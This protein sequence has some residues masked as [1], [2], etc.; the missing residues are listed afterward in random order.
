MKFTRTLKLVTMIFSLKVICLQKNRVSSYRKIDLCDNKTIRSRICKLDPDQRFV[1]DLFVKYAR[2]LKLAEKGYGPFPPPP[3]LVIEGNAGSGK[4]ELIHNLCMVL[5][6]EFRQAGDN[7]ENPYILKGSFTGEAACNIKGQTLTSLFNLGFGN[8]LS[9]MSDSLRDKKRD[10]LGNLK[11]LIID[12]YSM[13]RSDMTYQIDSRLKEIRIN[14]ECFGGVSV[15]LLGNL[16]QLQPVKG[17]YIFEEPVDDSW[18]LGHQFQSLWEL[19]TPIKL[20]Y[21]HRQD[22][23]LQFSNM[24]NR[25]SLGIVNREDLEL[26][27]TRV[28]RDDD[29]CIPQDTLYIFPLKRTVKK[30]NEKV[31]ESLEGELVVLKATNILKTRKH[32]E[33]YVDKDDDKVRNTPLLSTL[34]LKKNARVVLVY[35]IDVGDGLNNGAKG[36]VVDFVRMGN[37]V[38]YIIINLDNVES[39]K[40]LRD[41]H[42]N[43]SSGYENGT[44]LGK[45]TFS[46]SL[47]RKTEGSGAMCVQFPLNLGSAVTIHRVQ[48]ATVLPPKTITSDFSQIFEGS[49]AYTVI[50]RVKKLDQLYLLNDVYPHKIYTSPK[51]L[52]A[53]RELEGKAINCNSIGRREDQI[54]IVYLNCQNLITNIQ[55]IKGHPKIFEHNLIFLGET[56]VT[57]SLLCREQNAFQ[58]NGYTSNY[59]N[60]GRGKGLATFH[61]DNYEN[62]FNVCDINYQLAKYR[63]EILHNTLGNVGV[64]ILAI[65]RSTGSKKDKELLNKIKESLRVDRITIIVGDINLRFQRETKP[66]FVNEILKLNFDQLVQKSTHRE[67]G[68]IDHLYL[69]KPLMYDDVIISYDLFAPFYSDH[70][71]ISIVINKGD[72]P[73]LKMPCSIPDDINERIGTQKGNSKNSDGRK[74]KSSSPKTTRSKKGKN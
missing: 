15:V 20:T 17:R 69:R 32:F 30:Y 31:L 50:S 72:A 74:R 48:G 27:R 25:I 46:Y 28:F 1:L 6:K 54:K 34:Y 41:L 65:Y 59:L 67:G 58:L 18:K 49:Q 24:L 68:I 3:L 13:L 62:V 38:T 11:L 63:F 71:G 35:N 66:E 40:S 23:E 53:L 19:F 16:L 44:P 39:G 60:I 12:E 8:K 5:E 10:V 36:T 45:L 73:F 2:D 9:P 21:N 51:P 70:Y 26:L 56:W 52:A 61:E 7:P 14:R 33:P 4:S 64:D 37:E 47:S 43:V 55:D 57:D 42:K 22:G 29:P